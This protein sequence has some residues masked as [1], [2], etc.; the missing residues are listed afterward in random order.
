MKPPNSDNK[1]GAPEFR[2]PE[3]V[4]PTGPALYT[5]AMWRTNTMFRIRK[6]YLDGLFF[7]NY[8]TGLQSFYHREWDRATQSFKA[9]LDSFEDGPSRY[10]LNQIEKNGGKP[11]PNFKPYGI[12]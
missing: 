10:F 7:H 1:E 6:K 3:L 4:L 2:K 8:S 5:P 11:P 12:A 9:I